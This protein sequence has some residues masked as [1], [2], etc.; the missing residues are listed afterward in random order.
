M[1]NQPRYLLSHNAFGRL[2][3]TG[4]DGEA[5]E[6]IVPVRAFPITAPS[7]GI[8]LVDQ[9]GHELAWIDKLSD[10]PTFPALLRQASGM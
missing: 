9:H 8:A 7:C 4:A 2:I 10:L 1:I 6:G 3:F 5:H